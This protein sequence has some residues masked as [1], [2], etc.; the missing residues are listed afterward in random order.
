[1]QHLDEGTIHAW[2]DDALPPEEAARV[3]Q[4]AAECA[5]CAAAVADARGMIAG[6]ARIVS[7]LDIVRGD[8]IPAAAAKPA[9]H[10]SLWRKLHLTPARLGIAALLLVGVASMFSVTHSEHPA[11]DSVRSVSQPAIAPSVAA[12]PPV[13]TPGAQRRDEQP[14]AERAALAE[15]KAAPREEPK[16]DARAEGVQLSPMAPA[17]PLRAMA[18][19]P[20]AAADAPAAKVAVAVDS[21]R[22]RFDSLAAIANARM[23]R[24]QF[25][26]ASAAGARFN[27]IQSLGGGSVEGCYRIM[28]DSAAWLRGLPERFALGRDSLGQALVRAVS[29]AGRPD[30]V[31]IG[32]LWRPVVPNGASVVLL[33][34]PA[35]ER[36]TLQLTA[37]AARAEARVGARTGDVALQ[38]MVCRP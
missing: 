1:M 28:L 17:A 32:A 36:V 18:A 19:P 27:N 9:G 31:L 14:R 15:R 12:E 23:T 2:L 5:P 13:Q 6:A 35:G 21:A 38:R 30:S 24:A 7:S 10:D 22:S 34:Q 26:A 25:G 11:A 37:N 3:A 20:A 29:V 4:H 16:A 8:V 33:S